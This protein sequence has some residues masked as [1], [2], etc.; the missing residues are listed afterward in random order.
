MSDYCSQCNGYDPDGTH[1]EDCYYQEQAR[2]EKRARRRESRT[3][4]AEGYWEALRALWD[5]RDDTDC[6]RCGQ[7]MDVED[8]MLGDLLG[9]CPQGHMEWR[10]PKTREAVA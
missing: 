6:E 10:V 2:Q 7:P 1:P 3:Y 4:V 8:R 5:E 9:R